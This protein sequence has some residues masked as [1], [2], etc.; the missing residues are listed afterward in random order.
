[1]KHS[2]RKAWIKLFLFIT[3]IFGV[4][5]IPYLV[6]GTAFILGWDM[7]T[8]YSSNFEN[9]RTMLMQ[10]KNT[11]T[12]PYWSWVNFLGNDF[13]SSKLFYFNDFWEYFFAFTNLKYTDAIIWM[14]YLRF[15]TAGFSFYA[16]SRYNRYSQH[17]SI[18]GSLLFA[19]S[20]YL[21]Q[22]MR[23]PFFASFISFLPLYFLSVDRYIAEKKHGFFIFMVF[24]MFFNSYYLFYMTSLFTIL[25]FIWRWRKQY[26]NYEGL[27]TNAFRLIGYYLI[28]FLLSGVIV[29]PEVL[30][31]LANSRVGTRSSTLVYESIVPYLDYLSGLFTPVSMLAYRGTEISELY[32]YDTPNHQLMAMYV[33]SGAAAALLVPQLFAEKKDRKFHL[34]IL[35]LITLFSIVPILNSIMHGFSEPSFRWMANVTFLLIAEILPF[36]DH[37]ERIHQKLLKQTAVLISVLLAATPVLFA[38]ICKVPVSSIHSDYLLILCYIPFVILVCY[39]LRTNRKALCTLA[40]IAELC[41]VA[42]FTY[43]GNPTQSALKKKD[44]D[45]VARSMG[46]KDYYNEWTLSLD[47]ANASSFYRTYVDPVGVYWSQGTNYNLDADI[48]GL[49]AYDSTY[50]ASTNDLIR[51]D[52]D[53]VIDYLPWTFDIQNPDIITLVSTKYAVVAPGTVCPFQH[54]EQIGHYADYDL[55]LNLD[56]I[57]LGKTY[58]GILTYDDY[59]VSMSSL[60]TEKVICHTEDYDEI[61]ALIGNEEV[62]CSDAS[63]QGNQAFAT[64]TASEDGF[65]VLSVPYDKGWTVT[66]NGKQVKTYEVNGGMTGV[67]V[68]KG[69]NNIVF[70]FAPHGLKEGGILSIAGFGSAILLILRDRR[71]LKSH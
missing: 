32:L 55:Y 57:N 68:K 7:R 60:I 22:I 67:A 51:L 66:V 23:D 8:I 11:G 52:P 12:L 4:V 30:N 20:A 61:S 31:V 15:L 71:K 41:Y 37:P 29:I 43:Y 33:W 58:T 5:I 1:M 53:R 63:A 10:W 34:S 44:A 36:L 9:L 18:L 64:L 35:I 46:E 70:S 45:R 2:E 16:Y 6:T 38:L 39:A 62:E 49:L 13:Y 19:F 26:Q 28:G 40:V 47:P 21:L 56:Y 54:G 17:A 59:D 14:T 42:S 65:A 27:W 24:F 3:L 50:L 48:R 25:Y 69:E